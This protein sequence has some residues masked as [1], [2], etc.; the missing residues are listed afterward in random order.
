MR[1]FTDAP[2]VQLYVGGFL[3]EE[4][5]KGGA[6]YCQHG[7][8]CLETQLFLDAINQP[9]FPSPALRLGE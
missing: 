4:P 9:G 3:S 1:L 7:G 5:G 6:V 2:G 8:L